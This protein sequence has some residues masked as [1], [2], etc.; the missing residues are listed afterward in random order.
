MEL[1]ILAVVAGLSFASYALWRQA[2]G[3]EQPRALDKPETAGALTDGER[4]IHTVQP[5]DVVTT[6]G[7]DYLVEGALSLDDDGRVTRLYR[8]VDGGRTRWMA[9]RPGDDHPYLLDE[10]DLAVEANGPESIT[11]RGLPFRL[12]ARESVVVAPLGSVGEGRPPGRIQLWLYVGGGAARVLALSWPA[13]VEA[14]TGE[15][16][17]P[18]FVDILP[19]K[20]EAET[21]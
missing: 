10:S 19:G 9:A 8:L 3:G 2:R 18:H 6:L 16:L 11:F 13:R 4:T 7:V 12:A 1:I 15:R 21:A 5:G 14:F 17:E 20:P